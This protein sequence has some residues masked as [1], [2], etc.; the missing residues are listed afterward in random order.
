MWP[1]WD[2]DVF[3][4]INQA[5]AS[6][7]DEIMVLLSNRWIW[8]PM[9][10][11]L[12]YVIYQQKQKLF[13]AS[14]SYLVLSIVWADQISSSVL[15]PY[16]QRLRPCHVPAF[17]SWI[18]LPDGCGGLYGF[19]SSHAANSFALAFGFY[20][21]TQNKIARN[22]LLVWA[23]LVSYSRVYLGAHY[24]LDV[25]TG[26]IVGILGTYILKYLIYDKLVKKA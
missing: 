24:P 2:S 5:H 12:I 11:Y 7:L 3:Q 17:S 16:F 14:I 23:F 1:Q 9:Y 6:G 10:L 15:K 13:L 21:L 4:W 19:C 8:V 26:A 18:H 20:I 22:L 25:I